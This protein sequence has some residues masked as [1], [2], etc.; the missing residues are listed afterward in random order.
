MKL[1]MTAHFTPETGE[2]WDCTFMETD[3]GI[4]PFADGHWTGFVYA[5]LDEAST[6]LAI[7]MQAGSLVDC[8]VVYE[9]PKDSLDD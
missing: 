4:R 8:R 1:L 9:Y 2:P 6:D 3:D 7:E 5:S